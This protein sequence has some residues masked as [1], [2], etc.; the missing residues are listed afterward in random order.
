MTASRLQEHASAQEAAGALAAGIAAALQAGLRARG[1]AVLA[2]S[3]GSTPRPVYQVLSGL[4]LDWEHIHVVVADERWVETDQPG[5]NE[6][7]I[8]ETLL[9]DRA[10]R[11]RLT[12][13]KTEHDTP[14]AAVG[15]VNARLASLP[16]PFDAAVLGMGEDGHTLSW[17]PDA[18]GLDQA[19]DADGPLACAVTA[20]ESRVTGAH[21][22]RMTLTRAA[23]TGVRRADLVINGAAKR[24]ALAAADLPGPVEAMPVRALLRDASLA[25]SISWWP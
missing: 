17:F 2:A 25:F 8:R 18:E 4:D 21:T 1:A 11:A 5:S 23:L 22:R 16:R 12:G 15:A 10:A 9:R 24:D 13:L 3:G 19:L 20:R 7:L 6:A 14:Q